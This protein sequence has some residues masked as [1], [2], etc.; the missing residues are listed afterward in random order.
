MKEDIAADEISYFKNRKDSAYL[1][2]VGD[3]TKKKL[4]IALYTINKRAKKLRDARSLLKNYLFDGEE[5]ADKL[6][7][8]EILKN[9]K[10]D[11]DIDE[12]KDCVSS[13]ENHIFY[14]DGYCGGFSLR[15][16]R[17]FKYELEED[18]DTINQVI[19]VMKERGY[20]D[21]S[22]LTDN[23]KENVYWCESLGDSLS[24]LLDVTDYTIEELES[25]LLG[26]REEEIYKLDKIIECTDYAHE[27]LGEMREEQSK[28]YTLKDKIIYVIHPEPVARHIINDSEFL[29][30]QI[31]GFSFHIPSDT[32]E[33]WYT[34]E[35]LSDVFS[36]ECEE[37]PEIS[38]E[39]TLF[40][41]EKI[42]TEEAV[43]ILSE[44]L[45]DK[46]L[47]GFEKSKNYYN[48]PGYEE[49]DFDYYDDECY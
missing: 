20:K 26:D 48:P 38:A 7:E 42:S 36:G 21:T 18:L 49:I 46:D 14:I 4:G 47:T 10:A 24:N 43:S 12:W 16:L 40:E 35:E 3:N 25:D 17:D 33:M 6:D 11:Y 41:E 44:Y 27:L 30:F 13:G 19:N 2:K 9:F 15:E 28:L 1:R 34:E 45:N 31:G 29:M 37:I 22:E 32:A 39:N 8:S 5:Y 23:D